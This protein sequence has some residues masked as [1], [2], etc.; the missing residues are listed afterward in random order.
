MGKKTL[1]RQFLGKILVG[2]DIIDQKQMKHA[3]DVQKE[4]GGYFGKILIDL[5]YVNERDIVA[6]LV[7]QCHV[8]Y[9]AVDRYEI[10]QDII[11][12]IPGDIAKKYRIIP[13]DRVSNVLSVA[14]SDPMDT[15]ART[16][17]ENITNCQ[18][19]PFIST[20]GEISKAIQRWYDADLPKI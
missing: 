1:E 6:A 20:E 13:L 3:L 19:A 15:E 14:M 4:K 16:E 10:D 2:R 12:L 7:V 17:L 5:G 11:E 18:I 8:P 9:I